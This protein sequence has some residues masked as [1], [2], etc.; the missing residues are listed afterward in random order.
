MTA[1][2]GSSRP[3]PFTGAP[4]LPL[5]GRRPATQ[6]EDVSRL[7]DT[8]DDMTELRPRPDD[9]PDCQ[10]CSARLCTTA[11]DRIGLVVRGITGGPT[12]DGPGLYRGFSCA[13]LNHDPAAHATVTG[14]PCTT[15]RPVKVAAIP[16]DVPAPASGPNVIDGWEAHG[17]S[18]RPDDGHVTV[19]HNGQ[20]IGIIRVSDRFADAVEYCVML[21]LN[22]APWPVPM[23][24]GFLPPD[25]VRAHENERRR[26]TPDT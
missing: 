2:P 1:Q 6:W 13:L 18:H 8:P 12:I 3:T 24:V 25:P 17:V 16:S 19:L 7:G 23:P 26:W 11:R 15:D 22:G 10:C 9:C 5:T 14:C 20:V 4:H 21:D